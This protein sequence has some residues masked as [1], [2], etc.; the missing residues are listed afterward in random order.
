MEPLRPMSTGELLDRTFALYRK[1]FLLFVGIA[2]VTHA[3]YLGYQLLTIHSVPL[4]RNAR[5]GGAYYTSLILGWVFLTV[6]LTISQA[7]TVKAVAAVHLDQ[8]TSVWAAYGALRRRIVTVFGVLLLVLL[9][10]GLLTAIFVVILAVAMGIIVVAFRSGPQTATTNM[11]LGF[12]II[13][14]SFLIFVAVYVRYALA[15]QA[16]V[17]EDLG[18]WSSMKRS[19]ALSKGGRWRI[20]AVYILFVILSVTASSMFAILARWIGTPIH[21]LTAKLVLIY[22]GSLVSGAL[23]SPLATIAMSLLYY[24]ERVRKEAFDLHWMLATLDDSAPALPEAV[25]T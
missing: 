6:V 22:I 1:N 9:I 4:G 5:F 2:L 10:A 12:A 21:S 23:T 13:A 16:C 19:S 25:Q 11:V 18:A 14:G 20:A 24:D 17:V 15:I 8:A 7:A 3:V